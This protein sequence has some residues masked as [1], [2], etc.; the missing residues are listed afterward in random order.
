MSFVQRAIHS[1]SPRIWAYVFLVLFKL[2]VEVTCVFV[3]GDSALSRHC[4]PLAAK[5]RER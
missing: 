4:P 1:F 2:A 3:H 5:R